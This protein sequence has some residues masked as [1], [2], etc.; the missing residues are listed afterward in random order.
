MDKQM[1]YTH[2]SVYTHT[3]QY[4]DQLKGTKSSDFNHFAQES[5]AWCIH[6][7]GCFL[8]GAEHTQS[9]I[10]DLVLRLFWV[11]HLNYISCYKSL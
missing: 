11:N 10:F 7:S 8:A 3:I 4:A 5:N 6:L 1:Q 2:N 9:A